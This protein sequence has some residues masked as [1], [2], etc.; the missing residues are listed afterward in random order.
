MWCMCKAWLSTFCSKR[1][2]YTTNDQNMINM[3]NHGNPQSLELIGVQNNTKMPFRHF[4]KHFVCTYKTNTWVMHEQGWILPKYMLKCHKGPTQTQTNQM[5]QRPID[6]L[7]KFGDYHDYT[8]LSCF[9]LWLCVLHTLTQMCLIMP[10][11]C[12]T[13]AH[14]L[15]TWCTHLFTCHVFAFQSC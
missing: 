5:G 15:H 3:Y 2:K 12:I 13:Y 7:K 8:C 11:T 10:C 14:H 6:K 9:D 1:V 4:I